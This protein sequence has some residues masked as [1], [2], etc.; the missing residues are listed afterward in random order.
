MNINDPRGI[1]CGI[2]VKNNAL[3]RP[4]NHVICCVWRLEF[5]GGKHL[6]KIA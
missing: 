1:V 3:M 4:Q 5:V 2:S 6:G